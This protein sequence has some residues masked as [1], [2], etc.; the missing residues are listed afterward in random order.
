MATYSGFR[1]LGAAAVADD[2]CAVALEA[3]KFVAKSSIF[4][5][6]SL[7]EFVAD[8]AEERHRVALSLA[9]RRLKYQRYWG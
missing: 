1:P 6:K 9:H 5:V 8:R 7:I 2:N 4:A 3:N